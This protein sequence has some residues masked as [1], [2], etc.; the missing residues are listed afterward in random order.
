MKI[1]ANAKINKYL[2]VLGKRSDGFHELESLFI[3][4]NIYDEINIEESK[5]EKNLEIEGREA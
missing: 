1:K 5:E 2:K 4:I 3:P